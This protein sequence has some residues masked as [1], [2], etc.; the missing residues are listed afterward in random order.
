MGQKIKKIKKKHYSCAAHF[1]NIRLQ[2]KY[3]VNSYL[4]NDFDQV[5][6]NLS[7]LSY[8]FVGNDCSCKVSQNVW[9]HGLDGI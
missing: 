6:E 9:A 8:V 5:L 4:L 2:K 1:I 7:S 3:F